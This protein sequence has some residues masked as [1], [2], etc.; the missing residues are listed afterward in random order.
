MQMVL[1]KLNY[2]L[3]FQHFVKVFIAFAK[4]LIMII[5]SNSKVFQL[6]GLNFKLA[7]SKKEECDNLDTLRLSHKDKKTCLLFYINITYQFFQKLI[8]N[9]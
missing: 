5:K 3:F 4:F 1:H 6:L 2:F 9:Y 8:T 7:T